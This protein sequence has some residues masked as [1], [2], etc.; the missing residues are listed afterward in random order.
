MN[1]S[2]PSIPNAPKQC[3]EKSEEF[4]A[5]Q[6]KDMFQPIITRAKRTKRKVEI[7]PCKRKDLLDKMTLSKGM[8][9]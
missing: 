4:L 1:T 8:Q 2:I 5:E 9:R 3:D 7:Q 6:L